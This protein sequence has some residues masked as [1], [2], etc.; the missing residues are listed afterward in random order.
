MKLSNI[1][2]KQIFSIFDASFLGT[3]NDIAFDNK[4]TK[5]LGFYFFD[6][7]ENEFYIK[8][9]NIY[10]ID[11]FVTIKN[12][13]KIS[14]EF[15]LDKPLLPLGKTIVNIFGKDYGNLS[16]I[17]FDDKYKITSFVSNK[18]LSVLPTE[19]VTIHKNLSL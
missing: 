17:E 9:Q 1:I 11:D 4:Y 5:I 19:I 6:Q 12:S 16:D 10:A 13:S 18:N 2:G 15:L 7:D 8:T 3:I 14:S